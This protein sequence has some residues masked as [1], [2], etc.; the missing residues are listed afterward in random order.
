MI[1]ALPNGY[2]CDIGSDRESFYIIHE[3][4]YLNS[5]G[6]LSVKTSDS[7]LD[8]GAHVGL[9]ALKVVD[10]CSRVISVE[11]ASRNFTLLQKNIALNGLGEKVIPIR[12][13]INS[14]SGVPARLFLGE[15][16][17]WNSI[18]NSFG[19]ITETVESISVD[20]LGMELGVR[21]D[22][23]KI[24]VEGAEVE[25]LKGAKKTLTHSRE[26]ILE[27]HSEKLLEESKKILHSHGFNCRTVDPKRFSNKR[28][29][30][31]YVLLN[32]R[33]LLHGQVPDVVKVCLSA[34]G[35][36][37]RDYR[38]A[39]A[40]IMGKGILHARKRN[41]NGRHE[42]QRHHCSCPAR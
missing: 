23:I 20:D 16:G 28:W 14:K 11:P 9:F 6:S 7:V 12:R 25:L 18:Y 30:L 13:I 10:Q 27:Y 31:G 15:S 36:K 40:D 41:K 26:V 35:V 33:L 19:I 42:G 3:V 8:C 32:S 17:A 24:D 34:R 22:V 37:G 1:V 5:Y 21:F 29:F 2:R 38:T 4:F 39:H